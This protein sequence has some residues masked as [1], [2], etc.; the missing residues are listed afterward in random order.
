MDLLVELTKLV[1]PFVGVMLSFA[2]AYGAE[3]SDRSQ[4]VR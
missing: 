3:F 4:R 2:V 1:L